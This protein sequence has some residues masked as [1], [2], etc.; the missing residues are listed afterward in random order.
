MIN[1]NGPVLEFAKRMEFRTAQRLLK[2]TEDIEVLSRMCDTKIPEFESDIHLKTLLRVNVDEPLKKMIQKIDQWHEY[3]VYDWVGYV[4]YYDVTR[5]FLSKVEYRLDMKN[6][7][8]DDGSYFKMVR[9]RLRPGEHIDCELI[10]YGDYDERPIAIYRVTDF[11]GIGFH[12]D[13][14]GNLGS[15]WLHEKFKKWLKALGEELVTQIYAKK[16]V[17]R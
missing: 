2:K 17:T 10:F 11:E 7:S 1:N 14:R 5:E 8:Y 13:C 12:L 15:E 4:S 9:F 3:D 16:K 6:V